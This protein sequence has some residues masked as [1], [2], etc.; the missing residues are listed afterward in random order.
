MQPRL[1][2]EPQ[3]AALVAQLLGAVD[4]LVDELTESIFLSEAAYTENGRLTHDQLRGAVRDNLRTLLAA[5]RGNPMSLDAAIAA[6]RLKAGQGIPLAALLHAYRLAGRFIWER[7]LA[8]AEEAGC[9]TELLP[10]ASDIWLIIDEF[11]SAAADAYRDTVEEQARH[12]A[13]MRGILLTRLL[14][15]NVDSGGRARELLRTLRLDGHGLLLVVHAITGTPLA[16]ENRLRASGAPGVWMQQA[17]ARVGLLTV[18]DEEAAGELVD[19]LDE[20]ADCR[21]GVSRPFTVPTEAPGAWHQ[22]RQA[23]R[24][25]PAGHNGCHVYGSSPVS[26]LAAASPETAA[27]VATA[28]LGALLELPGQE[29]RLLLDTLDAWFAVGGSTTRAAEHLHCH[30]NTV[31]YRINRVQELTGRG[32]TD[33]VSS[34]ELY[35]ALRALRISAD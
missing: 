9:A 27:E 8:A 10:V 31:L 32:V 7:L 35:L 14:E 12:D 13:E 2:S 11:S 29:Q 16:V 5:L 1:V 15:G 18:T 34:A 26:L 24:C 28:V 20:A 3:V 21:I 4:P 22:A 17:D 19:L 25:L 33:A 30:R 6:G 23:A